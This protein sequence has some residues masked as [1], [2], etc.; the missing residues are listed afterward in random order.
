VTRQIVTAHCGTIEMRSDSE[1]TSVRVS[2]PRTLL[3]SEEGESCDGVAKLPG[4]IE[5]LPRSP[6]AE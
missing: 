3:R 5:A 4:D 2:L 6:S 1:A